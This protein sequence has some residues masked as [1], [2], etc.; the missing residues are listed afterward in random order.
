MATTRQ[1]LRQELRND[2]KIDPN[3][4]VWTDDILNQLIHEG[5]LEVARRNLVIP[6][7][8]TSTT[9]A[10]TVGS[11]TFSLPSDYL[12]VMSVEYDVE[13]VT[14]YTASTISFTNPSTISDSASGLGSFS[15]GDTLEIIGS[16]SNDTNSLT[17]ATVAAGT[18]T[19]TETSITTEGAGNSIT[20]IGRSQP[21]H[22]TMLR[23]VEDIR[24]IQALGE[25][26]ATG[27][28]SRYA[29][30]GQSLTFDARLKE[31]DNI[32]V[33]YIKQ[34]QEMTT[35]SGATGTS[36]IPDEM[37]PLVR[38]FA[39]YRAWYQLPDDDGKSDRALQRFEREFRRMV[40]MRGLD[41]YQ[42]RVYQ[43][44]NWRVKYAD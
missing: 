2:L 1:T 25:A 20:L 41:D 31:A 16:S 5:E 43:S 38:L 18:I 14:T 22:N 26:D 37:I 19:V 24:S 27:Y 6:E 34:P 21:D 32:K 30:F 12:R 17:I 15:A 39:A 33:T 35:D 9:T 28:P 13:T 7:L 42:L 4:D 44:A 10:G 23:R 11:N 8:Q 3:G 36:D 40:T 29:Q